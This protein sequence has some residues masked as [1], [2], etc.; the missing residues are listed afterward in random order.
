MSQSGYSYH[1]I[2]TAWVMSLNRL[3]QST[4]NTL[5][6][7]IRFGQRQRRSHYHYQCG[8]VVVVIVVVVVVDVIHSR[9]EIGSTLMT[10]IIN[11]RTVV[12]HYTRTRVSMII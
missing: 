12:I 9:H 5:N 4:T 1:P 2:R 7:R 6:R 3:K 10:I 8:V 11:R